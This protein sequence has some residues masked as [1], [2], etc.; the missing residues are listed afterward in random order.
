MTSVTDPLSRATTYAYDADSNPVRVTTPRGSTTR[1]YA[2][3]GPGGQDRLLGHQAPRRSRTRRLRTHAPEPTRRSPRTSSTIR[4][5]TSPTPA[6]SPVPTR[7]SLHESQGTRR[8][9]SCRCRGPGLRLL[10]GS[11][12]T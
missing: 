3:R 5:A 9:W 10:P 8:S 2:S 11:G 1:T 7:E 6:A 12:L 4:S